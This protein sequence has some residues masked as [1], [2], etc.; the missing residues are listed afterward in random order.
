MPRTIHTTVRNSMR[1]SERVPVEG[2]QFAD[3]RFVL[4]TPRGEL[5]VTLRSDSDP[6]HWEVAKHAVDAAV[7][8]DRMNDACARLRINPKTGESTTK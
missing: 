6:D 5:L 3:G 7:S 2:L 8:V 1:R 4:W